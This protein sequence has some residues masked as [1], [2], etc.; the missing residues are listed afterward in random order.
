MFEFLAKKNI[1]GSARAPEGTVSELP[2]TGLRRPLDNGLILEVMR[3]FP[4]G[5]KVRYY[6]SQ[7][8]NVVLESIVIAYG[9]NNYLV[10]TQNDIHVKE[11]DGSA[12]P[13]FLLDDDWKDVTVREVNSF[14][15]VIPD[16]GNSEN[17]LDYVSRVA[18][19]NNGLFKR[20]ETFTVMSLFAEKG[21][22]HI[23]V[24]VRKKVLLK[25]GYYANH[26]VIVL[27]ALLGTLHQIDQRQQCRIKTNIPISLY[28]SDDGEPF[29]CNL[30]DFSEYSLKIRIDGHEA[31]KPS[32]TK[33][34]NLTVAI[35]LPDRMK[36]FILKGK[37]LRRDDEYVVVSLVSHLVNRQFESLDLLAAIDLKANLL[38]HPETQ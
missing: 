36:S 13:S 17:E 8:K 5:G 16:I 37:V 26:S 15:L 31:L 4:I 30:V 24:Q 11:Q 12:A 1:H 7:R 27:E 23:D 14:C 34:R 9:L 35:D 2:D 19:D 21:V 28:L 29:A 3:Y 33:K 20:G 32:L 10:Y 25:E 22:P 38:Q 18:I 6:P